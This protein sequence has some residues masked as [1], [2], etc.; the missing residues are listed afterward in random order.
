MDVK[1]TNCKWN[2]LYPLMMNAFRGPGPEYMARMKVVIFSRGAEE[3]NRTLQTILSKKDE[4]ARREKD[5]NYFFWQDLQQKFQTLEAIS[6]QV[7]QHL[8]DFLDKNPADFNK[9]LKPMVDSYTRKFGS[10]L[11]S[12]VVENDQYFKT[13]DVRG[14]SLKR[15]YELMVRLT[16][17]KIGLES[18]K[19]IEEFQ[20]IKKSPNQKEINALSEKVKKVFSSLKQEIS[21]KLAQISED[22]GK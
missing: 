16:S 5:E 2:G 10:F 9:N 7:E 12:F 18:M 15:N 13:L 11:A 19:F 4:I 6:L 20:S 22:Q 21:K 14:A 17:K 8:L 3:F 1:A